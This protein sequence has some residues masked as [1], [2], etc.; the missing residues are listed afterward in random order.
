MSLLARWFQLPRINCKRYHG[1]VDPNSSKVFTACSRAPCNQSNIKSPFSFSSS[2]SADLVHSSC[3][4]TC[5]FA[6]SMMIGVLPSGMSRDHFFSV[7][8]NFLARSSPVCGA[9]PTTIVKSKGL[10]QLAPSSQSHSTKMSRQ[11]AGRTHS[12]RQVARLQVVGVQRQSNLWSNVHTTCSPG[13]ELRVFHRPLSPSRTKKTRAG[14]SDNRSCQLPPDLHRS[15]ERSQ[16]LYIVTGYLNR[17]QRLSITLIT[18]FVDLS[19]SSLR[20]SCSV[21][22]LGKSR[23]RSLGVIRVPLHLAFPFISVYRPFS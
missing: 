3:P 1:S 8:Q 16:C 22:P 15:F 9:R 12:L 23:R 6:S 11:V 18:L 21:I 5:A 14:H 4:H 19:F 13:E 17:V 2:S 10:S 7:S 20:F